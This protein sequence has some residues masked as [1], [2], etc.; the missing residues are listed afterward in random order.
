MKTQKR[1]LYFH[2]PYISGFSKAFFYLQVIIIIITI[3]KIFYNQSHNFVT[4]LDGLHFFDYH[5]FICA[6]GII[7]KLPVPVLV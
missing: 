2:A 4:G 7:H 3:D 5:Y 6:F 1:L